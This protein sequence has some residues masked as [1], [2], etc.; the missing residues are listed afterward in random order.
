MILGSKRNNKVHNKGKSVSTRRLV[1]VF[2]L[3]TSKIHDF[4]KHKNTNVI[5]HSVFTLIS[6]KHDLL[7]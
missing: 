6:H 5:N 4:I 1:E 7:P 3:K 2:K